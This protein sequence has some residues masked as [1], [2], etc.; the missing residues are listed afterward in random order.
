[1]ERV[2]DWYIDHHRDFPFRNDPDPY[3]IWIS[4][5][6][7]QQTR[8]ETVLPYYER[9]IAELPDVKTLAQVSDDRLL[10]L[11]EGL[12]Y[13]SRARNLKK[14]AVI[15]MEQHNGRIP[16]SYEALLKLPGIGEYTAGAVAS[17]A[18]HQPVP[19]V[20]GNV[21]RVWSRFYGSFRDVLD[22]D[23]RKEV[24]TSLEKE[25]L[26]KSLDAGLFNQGLM[27]LGETVCLP[28]GE[29]LCEACPLKDG[30]TAFREGYADR[31]PVRKTP[32]KKTVVKLTVF[33]LKCKDKTAVVKR[34]GKD[35]LKGLYGYPVTEG[36][37]TEEE[38]RREL[39]SNHLDAERILRLAEKKHVFTH[40]IWEMKAYLCEVQPVSGGACFGGDPLIFAADRELSEVYALPSAFRKWDV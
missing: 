36:H 28:K 31:L 7:L 19:V 8:M 16:E 37:L 14:A 24:R 10:K 23:V 11:W 30:C 38:V 29:L 12:G 25:I 26:S 5:I 9:F 15:I 35:V 40:R 4:E 32:E 17:I 21:L 39:A 20:D 34:S 33:I 18:F 6:M 27:E 2:I 3:H 22:N 1:M 13:Y